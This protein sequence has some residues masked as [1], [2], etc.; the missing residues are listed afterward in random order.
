MCISDVQDSTGHRY[1]RLDA[2]P[3]CA[4]REFDCALAVTSSVDKWWTTVDTF[5]LDGR[6]M[7]RVRFRATTTFGVAG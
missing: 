5:F 2:L 7:L 6:D 4:I 3:R 1:S